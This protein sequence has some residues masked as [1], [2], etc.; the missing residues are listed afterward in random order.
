MA[1]EAPVCFSTPIPHLPTAQ[2]VI[3]KFLNLNG[4]FNT[5]SGQ[6]LILKKSTYQ[7]K[8]ELQ[9]SP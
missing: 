4:L 2:L 9:S 6:S 1:A 3:Q 5:Y 7:I 8:Y